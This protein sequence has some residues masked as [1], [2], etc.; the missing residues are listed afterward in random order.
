M[1]DQRYNIDDYVYG[2]E[3]NDFLRQSIEQIPRGDIL[4]LAE[5][6]GRNAVFL[7]QHGGNVTA[8]DASA[9][10]LAKAHRLAV[11]RGASI[12]TQIADLAQ[13]Q[14]GED[15]WDGIISIFAHLPPPVRRALHEQV[16]QSLRP[17]GIFLLEAYTPQQLLYNTGG[18][19][20]AELLMDLASL[21]QELQGLRFLHAQE[22]TREIH[23]GLFHNGTSAVVQI[24][25]QRL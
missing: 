18:P 11:E 10:G 21:Q 6:E 3:P 9:I 25:A 14:L 8:V 12:T 1:W 2:K 7:A 16:V 4:C 19:P 15:Q 5:G 23:E 24:I 17:G 22:C 20:N 13:F